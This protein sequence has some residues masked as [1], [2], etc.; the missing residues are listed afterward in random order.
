[1]SRAGRCG[2]ARVHGDANRA[3]RNGR[4]ETCVVYDVG[5]IPPSPSTVSSGVP[6]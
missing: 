5:G 1:M 2:P 4:R 3:V 6:S